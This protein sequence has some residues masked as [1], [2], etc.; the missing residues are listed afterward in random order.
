MGSEVEVLHE[1]EERDGT[2]LRLVKPLRV[3]LFDRQ[4][5]T[6]RDHE[7]YTRSHSELARLAAENKRLRAALERVE[8]LDPALL[9]SAYEIA[10]QALEAADG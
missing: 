6:W 2:R 1:W 10:R 3:Q 9:R 7:F 8:Q 5:G 4:A